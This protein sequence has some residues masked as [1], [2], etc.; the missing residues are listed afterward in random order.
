MSKIPTGIA[1]QWKGE[2]QGIER[3]GGSQC[4]FKGL[5]L[6]TAVIQRTRLPITSGFGRSLASE[7]IPIIIKRLIPPASPT[8]TTALGWIPFGY[9]P[10]DDYSRKCIQSFNRSMFH[11]KSRAKILVNTQ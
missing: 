1:S 5:T 9:V 8:H 4:R 7:F 10:G 3:E 6:S 11:H 2:G